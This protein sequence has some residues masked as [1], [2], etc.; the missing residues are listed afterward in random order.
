VQQQ[1]QQFRDPRVDQLIQQFQTREQQQAQEAQARAQAETQ[2]TTS[3]VDRWMN[4]A[5]AAGNPKRPYVGDVINEMSAL[6]PQLKDADPTLTHAQALEQAYERATWAHP[7][8]RVLLQQQ[9]QQALD[10]KRRTDSQARVRDARRASSVNVP[11]RSSLPSQPPTGS[12]EET[13]ASTAR[14]LGLIS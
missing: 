1:A 10:A 12:L 11:R 2:Q 7:E 4:E 8:I 14:E 9:Q 6:I 13:I 5:D 3:F